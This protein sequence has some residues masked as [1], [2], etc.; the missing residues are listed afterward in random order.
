MGS[1]SRPTT[2]SSPRGEAPISC[3][4]PSV[5]A[6]GSSE[7]L[8]YFIGSK[9]A[10]AKVYG[11]ALRNHWGIENSLHWQLD[12][13][14]G[15]DRC[16]IQERNAAK[17]FASMRKLALCVLK[18]HHTQKSIPRKRK[19]AAQNPDF[20]AEILTGAAKEAKV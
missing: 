3:Q 11:K 16:R 2:R 8:R 7:E 6:A 19:M 10:S 17:N 1:R 12:V 4:S 9:K 20:L 13:H 14:F 15:E 5:P 18:R